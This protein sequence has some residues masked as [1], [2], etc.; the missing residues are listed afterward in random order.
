MTVVER[1][2]ARVLQAVA[3][4][5]TAGLQG[6]DA[7]E[8][9]RWA[10]DSFAGRVVATQAMANTTMSHLLTTHA[11][12]IPIVFLDTGY[13]FPETLATR[14]DLVTRTGAKLLT[15]TPVQSVAEQDEQ[16]GADLW[17][18][19]PD[20]CCQL[21]KVLP[22]EESLIGYEAWITGLRV[23]SSTSR[24][25][26]PVVQFDEKRGVLKIS[27]MLYWTDEQLLQYTL[28]HDVPVNPLMYQGY[29]SIGCGPCTARVEPGDDP[30]SGRWKGQDKIECGLHT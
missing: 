11:P 23:A 8:I 25:E 5:A 16:Y 7:V 6:A 9:I 18:R 12:E 15:I 22:M 27:P 26:V 4:Y 2:D 30:R 13:H 24:E 10:A 21:R 14:D 17:A 28:E 19:D 20:L 1:S 29:P 3:R